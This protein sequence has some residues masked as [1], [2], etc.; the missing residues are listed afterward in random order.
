[1]RAKLRDAPKHSPAYRSAC[2]L[3]QQCYLSLLF[4]QQDAPRAL[5]SALCCQP[6]KQEYVCPD[7]DFGG[8][9]RERKRTPPKRGLKVEVGGT[10]GRRSLCPTRALLS[11][12]QKPS[13]DAYHNCAKIFDGEKNPA[14]ARRGSKFMRGTAVNVCPAVIIS[15][16]APPSL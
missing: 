12:S 9:K 13:C 5:R 10:F 11:H 15:Q 3:L 4:P 6:W 8:A 1:M 2:A 7:S 16:L 14:D